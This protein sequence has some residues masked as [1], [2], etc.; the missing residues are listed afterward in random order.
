VAALT[1]GAFTQQDV[2]AVARAFSGWTIYDVQK[3]AE[4]QFNPGGH[5]RKEKV[6]LGHTLP[7]GRGEQDGLDVI[8]ILAQHPSTAKFISKKLAQRFVADDPPQALVDRMATT[9]TKTNGDLRAV[10][11]TMLSSVEF[12]SEGAWQAKLKSPLEMVVSSLR[13]MN[14]DVNDTFVLAQRVADLGQPLYGKIEP[15]GYP[16]TADGWTNTAGV[17][18]RI[19]FSTALTAGQIPGV[20][21]DMSRFNFKA[22]AAVAAEILNS[23]PSA[24]TLSAIESG[25]KDKEATPSLLTNLVM[26]S[27][28][29]QRK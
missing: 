2:I 27:P 4:F 24:Q 18:G 17:L 15:T 10:M 28:D 14:A 6:I 13:I 16:N 22:P 11:Q 3:Y 9:F 8:D 7:A 19:N 20:K 26:S 1:I 5:D 23:A 12:M 25:L 29:F 21:I